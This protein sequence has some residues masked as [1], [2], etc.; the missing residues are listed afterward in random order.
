MTIGN[1]QSGSARNPYR[2]QANRLALF[3]VRTRL[4]H[5]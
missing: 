5:P 4:R 1:A 3:G 2:Q